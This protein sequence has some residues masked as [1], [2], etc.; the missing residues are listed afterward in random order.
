[1]ELGVIKAKVSNF[2]R[3]FCKLK[4]AGKRKTTASLFLILLSHYGKGKD[5]LH[6][7]SWDKKIG[8]E[9]SFKEIPGADREGNL[10]IIW[11]RRLPRVSCVR[12]HLLAIS[13]REAELK[14]FSRS[15]NPRKIKKEL[16]SQDTKSYSSCCVTK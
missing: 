11:G 2:K 13:M 9:R 10:V 7:C 12:L 16:L 1:M 14:H 8:W 6:S 15:R 3:I 4:D 5:L